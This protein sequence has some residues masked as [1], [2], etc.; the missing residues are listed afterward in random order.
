MSN[1]RAPRVFALLA[2]VHGQSTTM[3]I[4]Q[5]YW[6]AW[7]KHYNVHFPMFAGLSINRNKRCSCLSRLKPCFSVQQSRSRTETI[8]S[9]V[10]SELTLYSIQ[11]RV[12]SGV[13]DS[14]K[15]KNK[16]KHSQPDSDPERWP[17]IVVYGYEI[18]VRSRH[19]DWR[20]APQNSPPSR[21]PSLR[22]QRHDLAT[23]QR[24]HV[25]TIL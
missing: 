22:L 13:N 7:T 17:P 6:A 1:P 4:S 10:V 12:A 24:D 3:Y 9:S 23:K 21:V 5:V 18:P 16:N 11:S 8:F 2:T 14:R 19:P 25:Y 20:P 15:N